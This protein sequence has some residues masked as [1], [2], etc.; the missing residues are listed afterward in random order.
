[1]TDMALDR[2]ASVGSSRAGGVG[3]IAIRRGLKADVHLGVSAYHDLHA[4]WDRLVPLQRSPVLFQMPA[5]LSAW[6]ELFAANPNTVLATAVVRR[7]DGRAVLIWPILVE[8]K[9]LVRIARGAASPVGQ[10]DEFLVDPECDEGAALAA[11]IAALKR[12]AR[13]DLFFLER[14]RADSALRAAIG[15]LAA[16]SKS[17]GAPYSDLSRGAEALFETLKP[18]VVQQ[19]RKRLRRLEQEGSV[20]FEIAE[21]AADAERWLT[22]A[23]AIKREWLRSTGRFSRAFARSELADLLI[24]YTRTLSGPDSSPRLIVSRLSVNGRTAAYEMGFL[25]RS[26]F[27]SYLGAFSPEFSKFG[28]GNILSG[29]LLEWCGENGIDRL[30]M[31]SPRSRSKADWQTDEIEV[32]DFAI[33]TT[34][35]GRLYL[36]GPVKRIVPAA[37]NAFYRLPPAVRSKLAGLVLHRLGRERGPSSDGNSEE[38]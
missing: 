9:G 1:M 11:A 19:H 31:Q 37:R 10:Y 23:M 4:D 6:A 32:F 35:R 12:G 36:E 21:N 34:W 17:E 14:V 27:H 26:T 28:A 7:E 25:H 33:P 20:S 38:T 22:E 5:M 24:Q 29:K 13:P 15:S 18:R 2:L 3:D 30:D 16:P 8:R